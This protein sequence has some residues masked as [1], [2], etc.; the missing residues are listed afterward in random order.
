M[1]YSLR[2]LMIGAGIVLAAG[3]LVATVEIVWLLYT[4][5]GGA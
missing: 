5:K 1:K 3:L 2:S 4:V